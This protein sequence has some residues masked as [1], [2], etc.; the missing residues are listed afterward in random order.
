MASDLT[1]RARAF[2]TMATAGMELSKAAQ[3]S[4][5]MAVDDDA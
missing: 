4:G 2:S 1:G 3:L 5:L